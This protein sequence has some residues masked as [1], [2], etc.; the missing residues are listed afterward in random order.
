MGILRSTENAYQGFRKLADC[1]LDASLERVSVW[2]SGIL[3][4]PKAG[5]LTKEFHLPVQVGE[6]LLG[7]AASRADIEGGN[8][9]EKSG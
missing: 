2:V 4:F 8:T 7:A 5:G 1:E 9:P 6:V 3:V